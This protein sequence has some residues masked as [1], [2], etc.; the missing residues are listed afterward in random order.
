MPAK[1][2]D[3]LRGNKFAVLAAEFAH[4]LVLARKVAPFT[5]VQWRRFDRRIPDGQSIFGDRR[6]DT[7][8]SVDPEGDELV[9][10]A[11]HLMRQFEELVGDG[12]QGAEVCGE[13][14]D[15]RA[16]RVPD[17]IVV[18]AE[19]FEVVVVVLDDGPSPVCRRPPFRIAFTDPG[20]SASGE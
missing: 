15:E 20:R 14:V 4:V 2:C 11:I 6:S 9:V 12:V 10:A 19:L 16:P 1:E 17:L 7:T 5:L 3:R 8:R 13:V 18:V